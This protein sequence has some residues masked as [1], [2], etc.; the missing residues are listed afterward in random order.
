M[1]GD[2]IIFSDFRTDAPFEFDRKAIFS[3]RDAY[4]GFLY[5]FDGPFDRVRL[6]VF[7]KYMG[8]L[9]PALFL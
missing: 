5:F 3:V 7:Q 2:C 9:P 6:L 8:I 4:S 1:E